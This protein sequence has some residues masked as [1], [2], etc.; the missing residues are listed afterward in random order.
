MNKLIEGIITTAKV[1]VSLAVIGTTLFFGAQLFSSLWHRM[2]E[3][4]ARIEQKKI[5]AK[6][7]AHAKDHRVFDAI[8]ERQNKA[9]KDR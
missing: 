5:Q 2:S 1:I 6:K 7:E 4:M 3:E 9:V 8:M